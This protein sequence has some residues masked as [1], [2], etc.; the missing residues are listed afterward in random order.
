M[1]NRR[2]NIAVLIAPSRTYRRDLLRGIA[3]YA[4]VHGP[5]SFYHHEL[6]IGK[7]LPTQFKKWDGDGIIVH[8]EHVQIIEELRRMNRPIVG[9]INLPTSGRRRAQQHG[10]IAI[11]ESD[12]R[13]VVQLAVDHLL[14]HGFKHFAY[15]G[16]AGASSLE[17]L[18]C[19]YFLQY[20][21]EL[22]YTGSAY[23]GSRL[24]RVAKIA[25]TSEV[26]QRERAI[27]EWIRSLPK[28][29]GV[30]GCNDRAAHQV[31][32]ACSD[33][34]I[35]VPDEVA[36]IGVDNDDV[37]CEL[38]DPPL[39]SVNPNARRL[40]Y[41]MAALLHHLIRGE[42]P[43]AEPLLVKPL[44]VV[45]R[46]STDVTAVNDREAAAAMRFIRHHA[47]EGIHVSNVCR[48]VKLSR[49]TLE[50]RFAAAFG[51]SSRAEIARVQLVR[52]KELLTGTDYTLDKIAEM[53]G[54][55]YVESLCYTF[56]KATGQTP[57]EY[58]KTLTV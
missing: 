31:L 3:A 45:A 55:N 9:Q 8:T 49:S 4:R 10:E 40:G 25:S 54:F 1:T 17:N 18:G 42:A 32:T 6:A 26:H 51:H 20:V 44:G 19:T 16:F 24:S 46:E 47:C 13:A 33:E 30:M 52:I 14:E 50:R 7:T 37:L 35:V 2:L 48:H 29:V 21:A 57:S 12:Q 43:P 58:R 41:E 36:V 39:S 23:E 27:A 56:K 15:C 5:W 22:G 38:C 53:T 28:P 34:G 11:V